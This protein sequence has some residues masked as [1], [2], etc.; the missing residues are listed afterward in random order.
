MVFI[1]W[2]R[3]S[4]IAATCEWPLRMALWRGVVLSAVT[5]LMSAPLFSRS[6]QTL[7]C[8][9]LQ[10]MCNAVFPELSLA[11][12]LSFGCFRRTLTISSFPLRAAKCNGVLPFLPLIE[13]S[14]PPCKRAS[15]VSRPLNLQHTKEGLTCQI[16]KEKHYQHD[17][18]KWFGIVLPQCW[19]AMK[20]FWNWIRQLAVCFALEI[21]QGLRGETNW[22]KRDWN[23]TW[24]R[25]ARPNPFSSIP[26]FCARR[27]PIN[28]HQT[29]TEKTAVYRK[30]I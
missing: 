30:I 13:G 2:P 18:E 29:V 24:T 6:W 25:H 23:E 21:Q 19:N 27:S 26:T 9:S 8:P 22:P 14:A 17:I 1:F 16:Y 11:L 28:T 10:A 15:T 5:A 12:T 20:N 7:L 4:I 3:L